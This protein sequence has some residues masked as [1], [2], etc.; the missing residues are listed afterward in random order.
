MRYEPRTITLLLHSR[1]SVSD[2][3]NFDEADCEFEFSRAPS[4]QIEVECHL[5][6]RPLENPLFCLSDLMRPVVSL[7]AGPELRHLDVLEV[8]Q[9]EVVLQVML[10]PSYVRVC[11]RPNDM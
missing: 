11:T 6:Q 8:Y 10:L 3:G 1:S 2:C 5:L 7:Q 4:F 9:D